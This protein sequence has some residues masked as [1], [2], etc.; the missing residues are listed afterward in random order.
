M[1]TFRDGLIDGQTLRGGICYNQHGAYAIVL[2]DEDERNCDSP[3]KFTYRCRPNE[4]G[5]FKLTARCYERDNNL[6]RVFRTHALHSLWA[7]TAGIRFDG[8]WVLKIRVM[9]LLN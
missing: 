4:P 7:P 1:F 2:C 8:M 5:A 3:Q 9:L 6:I